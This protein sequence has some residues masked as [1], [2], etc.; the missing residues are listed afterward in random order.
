MYLFILFLFLFKLSNLNLFSNEI[1]LKINLH[2]HIRNL[3]VFDTGI[4]SIIFI[5]SYFEQKIY[6][7]SDEYYLNAKLKKYI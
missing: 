6:I 4:Y 7:E 1:N 3:K 2:D 5:K